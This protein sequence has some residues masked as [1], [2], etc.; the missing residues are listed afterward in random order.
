MNYKKQKQHRK[1]NNLNV[2]LKNNKH[3]DLT[4]EKNKNKYIYI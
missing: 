2:Y 4:T 3:K 1:H